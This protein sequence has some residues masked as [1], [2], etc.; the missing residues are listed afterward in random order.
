M[1]ANMRLSTVGELRQRLT[2]LANA[3]VPDESTI[4]IR[5]PGADAIA[6]MSYRVEEDFQPAEHCDA[7]MA[8]PA[9][10]WTV[11]L[12]LELTAP[13]PVMEPDNGSYPLS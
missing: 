6:A 11:A 12:V 9:G 1:L 2:E 3:G 7:G 5:H 10:Y 8:E 13:L 4:I